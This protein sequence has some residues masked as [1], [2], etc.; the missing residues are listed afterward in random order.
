MKIILLVIFLLI[1]NCKFNKIVDN[2]GIHYLDKKQESLT[3]NSSNKND[4]IQLLGPP[5]TK[6]KF[7]NDLWIYIERKK[8]RTTLFKFGRKLIYVNHVLLLEIDNKGLLAKKELLDINDMKE[9][10]F[11]DDITDI[12]YSKK[13]FVYDFLSS[14]RQKINDPL[15]VRAEK[16]KN[17]TSNNR[18]Q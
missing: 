3:V 13:S 11:V 7:D 12:S 8:T 16:R 5:S 14:M 6:S 9:V 15:G 17:L 18:K 1:V 2:H 4:I 10:I